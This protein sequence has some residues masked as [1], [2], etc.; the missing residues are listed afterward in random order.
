MLT[1]SDA[2]LPASSKP[3]I[4]YTYLTLFVRPVSSKLEARP[5]KT[6]DGSGPAVPGVRLI[7]IALVSGDAVQVNVAVASSQWKPRLVVVGGVASGWDAGG[8]AA[9][10]LAGFA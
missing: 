7:S 6:V 2:L 4:V 8:V 1:L 10:G 5:L 9:G 3:L